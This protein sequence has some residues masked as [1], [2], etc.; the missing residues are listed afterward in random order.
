MQKK[1]FRKLL[2]HGVLS[3]FVA[4][5][6]LLFGCFGEAA[7]TEIDGLQLHVRACFVSNEAVTERFKAEFGKQSLGFPNIATFVPSVFSFVN[8][9]E[10][11]SV[12]L[13]EDMV[14][15]NGRNGSWRRET[16]AEE[17]ALYWEL[18]TIYKISN[19]DAYAP[20][21][22]ERPAHTGLELTHLTPEESA[23]FYAPR[24]DAGLDSSTT[25]GD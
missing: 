3:V 12:H 25:C 11:F 23:K 16:T 5:C 24:Q 22:R 19:K 21:N 6:L 20:G 4:A 1:R 8:E 9:R 10:A 17:R 13:Y 18:V 7:P 14:L 15:S 2:S